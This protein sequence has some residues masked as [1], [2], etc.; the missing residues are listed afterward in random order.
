M[1]KDNPP[2]NTLLSKQGENRPNRGNRYDVQGHF[3]PNLVN[4]G[5]V[6]TSVNVEKMA[7][8][9]T[10]QEKKMWFVKK[11]WSVFQK[12]FQDYLN[13]T[14][15][16]LDPEMIKWFSQEVSEKLNVSGSIYPDSGL[17]QLGEHLSYL[18]LAE[19]LAHEFVH[20]MSIRSII[21]I[22]RMM[23]FAKVGVNLTTGFFRVKKRNFGVNGWAKNY[24]TKHSVIRA[25]NSFDIF[26]EAITEVFSK[27]FLKFIA[28][29][30]QEIAMHAD[31]I[32]PKAYAD[33]R[34]AYQILIHNVQ[35]AVND[36]RIREVVHSLR[37]ATLENNS[38]SQT[39]EGKR[40]NLQVV[41]NALST[42]HWKEKLEEVKAKYGWNDYIEEKQI[43]EIFERAL[44]Y[45]DAFTD[46]VILITRTIGPGSFS[47]IKNLTTHISAQ[48]PEDSFSLPY[49]E[50][51]LNVIQLPQKISTLCQDVSVGITSEINFS[52]SKDRIEKW[53]K[54]IYSQKDFEVSDN[55]MPESLLLNYRELLFQQS[56]SLDDVKD[57]A[58][59]LH[60]SDSTVK[61]QDYLSTGILWV[62]SFVKNGYTTIDQNT[63]LC[64]KE[65]RNKLGFEDNID[66]TTRT[67]LSGCEIEVNYF[68][69]SKFPSKKL[70]RVT[71]H[72]PQNKSVTFWCFAE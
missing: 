14:S 72:L 5:T 62:E 11:L 15:A 25:K 42:T 17:I 1:S 53:Y 23:L 59:N 67:S 45:K 34:V 69:L 36:E 48:T 41:K 32:K 2:I 60:W 27:K 38:K 52:I 31:E 35:L 63:E 28:P 56:L 55:V 50:E 12:N 46:L 57:L 10:E 51:L 70:A 33:A 64:F 20:F 13:L 68:N 30:I 58:K 4:E 40:K 19:T 6:N 39:P 9:L 37:I 65:M 3:V 8:S 61:N 18:E 24:I 49:L 16:D 54:E 22:N 43:S 21:K 71:A 29:Q 7:L 66:H 44:F 47:Q 26:N